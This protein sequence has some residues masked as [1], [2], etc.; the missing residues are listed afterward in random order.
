MFAVAALPALT[1]FQRFQPLLACGFGCL[2]AAL[3]LLWLSESL[4]A[5][6]YQYYDAIHLSTHFL[7]AVPPPLAVRMLLVDLA[8]VSGQAKP[9]DFWELESQACI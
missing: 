7:R 2:I 6:W 3:Q 4:M 9:L 1:F 8:L 5:N